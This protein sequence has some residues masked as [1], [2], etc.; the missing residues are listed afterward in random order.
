MG[1]LD[2]IDTP[3]AIAQ[4]R[5]LMWKAGIG[6]TLAYVVA[7]FGVLWF[8]GLWAEKGAGFDAPELASTENYQATKTAAGAD[9]PAPN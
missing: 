2:E 9:A 3:E 7:L 1:V 6:V 4:A 8:C 5:A